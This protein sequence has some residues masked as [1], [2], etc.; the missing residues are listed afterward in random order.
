MPN[1]K[2]KQYW[3]NLLLIVVIGAIYQSCYFSKQLD[4]KVRLSVM[5]QVPVEINVK[6]RELTVNSSCHFCNRLCSNNN[7]LQSNKFTNNKS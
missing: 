4:R 1:I 6:W 2:T 5:Q 3:I 7:S